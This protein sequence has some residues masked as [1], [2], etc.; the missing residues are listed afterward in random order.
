M[1]KEEA[2]GRP[3]VRP[4]GIPTALEPE[5]VGN[6]RG[7][8][9]GEA[10]ALAPVLGLESVPEADPTR[11]V[12]ALVLCQLMISGTAS[13]G[14]IREASHGGPEG[15]TGRRTVGA[16]NHQN[17][18]DAYCQ[19]GVFASSPVLDIF[20]ARAGDFSAEDD[21]VNFMHTQL[22]TDLC[23]WF[24]PMNIVLA[25]ISGSVIGF[26]VA[27]IV[28]PPY[29]FFKFT[30]IQIGIG[31]S[32][33]GG[34]SSTVCVSYKATTSSDIGVTYATGNIGNVP[35]VLIAALCRDRNNPFGDS[36]KCSTDGT[37]YI[38]FGQWAS[39]LLRSCL[40]LPS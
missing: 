38:S 29:P 25:T 6:Q 19:I 16:C 26:I 35:L 24:I 13:H 31:E 39:R 32:F 33:L 40:S 9:K 2:A 1:G 28:H 4:L 20:T 15:D 12:P 36:D 23:R 10:T 34:C 18:S 30:I 14:D 7:S 8:R 22:S 37:A 21:G 17:R 11:S 5:A 3:N 27:S